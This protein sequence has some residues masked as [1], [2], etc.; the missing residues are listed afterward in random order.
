MLLVVANRLKVKEMV[1]VCVENDCKF[2]EPTVL[3]SWLS[4]VPDVCYSKR[5]SVSDDE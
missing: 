1:D 5:V 4:I 3:S 2:G